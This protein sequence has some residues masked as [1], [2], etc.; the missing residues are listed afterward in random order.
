MKRLFRATRKQ[1]ITEVVEVI[2]DTID[3]AREMFEEEDDEVKILSEVYGDLEI[4]G[5]IDEIKI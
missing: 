4:S 1:T 5:P 3:E 2:A